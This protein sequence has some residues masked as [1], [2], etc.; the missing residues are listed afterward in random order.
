[1]TKKAKNNVKKIGYKKNNV[2]K[3]TKKRWQKDDMS[4]M[5]QKWQQKN[6][7]K[8]KLAKKRQKM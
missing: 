4:K 6:V 1:M 5:Q 2:N 7:T 8:K 3:D